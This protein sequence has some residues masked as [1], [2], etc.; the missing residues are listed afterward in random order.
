MIPMRGVSSRGKN[1]CA[2]SVSDGGQKRRR[3]AC[4]VLGVY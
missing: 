2:A 3:E 1:V 4:R